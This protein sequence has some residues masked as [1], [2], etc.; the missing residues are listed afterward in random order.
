MWPNPQ[1]TA[2]LVTFTEEILNRKLDFLCNYCA[3]IGNYFHKNID[4]LE[5][6]DKILLFHIIQ[7]TFFNWITTPI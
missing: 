1:K 6:F 3:N 4:L 5:A 7:I 2:D